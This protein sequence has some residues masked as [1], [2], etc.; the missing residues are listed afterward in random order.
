[1]ASYDS[2]TTNYGYCECGCGEKTSLA[3]TTRSD[4]GW[5]KGEPVR[6]ISGHNTTTQRR[7]GE[8]K[9]SSVFDR[10]WAK[11]AF[12]ANPDRCW[13]WQAAKS[14]NGYGFFKSDKL[15]HSH[16]V[17]YELTYGKIDGNLLVCHSCDNRLCCNPAHLFLGTTQQNTQDKVNKGRQA[18]GEKIASHKLTADQIQYIRTRFATG[19][20]SKRQIAQEMKVGVENIRR[21]VKNKSWQ[22]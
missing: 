2:T 1:M 22:L 4:R 9:A 8:V 11:V 6:F 5:V 18:K 3:P 15:K 14:T 20:Y 16:R 21:I 17:A 10:F 12:T 19:I 13:D 7:L